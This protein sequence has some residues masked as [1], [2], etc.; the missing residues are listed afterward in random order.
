MKD[1]EIIKILR[2]VLAE[3]DPVAQQALLHSLVVGGAGERVV[4]IL[5]ARFRVLP[6]SASAP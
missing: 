5:G 4:G 6:L 3:K 2:A 1:Q